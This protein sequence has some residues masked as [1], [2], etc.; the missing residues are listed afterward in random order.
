MVQL[1]LSKSGLLCVSSFVCYL[2]CML[3][4]HLCVPCCCL[5]GGS[6]AHNLGVFISVKNLVK[7][8]Y[9]IFIFRPLR[10]LILPQ[11]T[12]CTV[13]HLYYIYITIF[14]G[15]FFQFVSFTFWGLYAVDRELV[16][17]A[18]L[19]PYFPTWL[20]H[21]MHT[22]VGVWVFLEML[23]SHRVYSDKWKGLLG[24]AIFQS[25]YLTW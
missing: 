11:Y 7:S 18:V 23:T 20:N 8:C 1:V 16:L 17:P 3:F 10:P 6:F 21:I 15:F 14:M 25:V 5:H 2:Q 12:Q 13:C 4:I 22:A 24:L 19:D 9:F